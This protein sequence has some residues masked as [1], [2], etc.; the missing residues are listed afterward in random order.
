MTEQEYIDT[1]DLRTI[2]VA[3]GV[4]SG[5]CV[6]NQPAIS[7]E[8]WGGAW[9]LLRKWEE[10]L[11]AKV[12]VTEESE[13]LEFVCNTLSECETIGSVEKYGSREAALAARAQELFDRCSEALN[14]HFHG[15]E[16]DK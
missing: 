3:M 4:L 10:R 6:E 1:S 16:D 11:E 2:R 5:I 7:R 13:A 14:K 9:I 12:Q 15:Q 8:E